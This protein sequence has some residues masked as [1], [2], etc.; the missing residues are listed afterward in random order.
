MCD[1]SEAYKSLIFVE[2][3]QEKVSNVFKF[4]KA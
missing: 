4:P 1:D 3:F 2:K